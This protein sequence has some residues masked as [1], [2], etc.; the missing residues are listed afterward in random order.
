[1]ERDLYRQFNTKIGT[2][3]QALALYEQGKKIHLRTKAV[4][5]MIAKLPA[6]TVDDFTAKSVALAYVTRRA[7]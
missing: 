1:M 5:K 3:E 4:V 2:G 7:A 6:T